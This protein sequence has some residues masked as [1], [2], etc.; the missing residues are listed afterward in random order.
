MIDAVVFD[1]DGLMFDTERLTI[2]AHDYAGEQLGLENLG[3]MVY[4][5]LG[6]NPTSIQRVYREILGEDFP[7][8]EFKQLVR[9]FT[10]DYC[11]KNG[12]PVKPGLYELL[13]YLKENGYKLGVATSTREVSAMKHFARAEVTHAFDAI[14]CGDQVPNGKPEPDIYL[15]CCRRLGVSPQRSMALEDSP[16]GLTAA[17]RAGMK[18]VMIPDL[19]QPND[20]LQKILFAKLNSLKDVPALLETFKE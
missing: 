19:I 14:V 20:A 1:M 10:D 13:D 5:T 3:V 9:S 17:Y 12:L 2:T 7:F 16:N 11:E 18:A 6:L 4:K 15:E 8:E